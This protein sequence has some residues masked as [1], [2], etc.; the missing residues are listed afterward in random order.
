VRILSGALRTFLFAALTVGASAQAALASGLAFDSV[1]KFQ[2]A[3]G[4]PEPPG[5]FAPD[6]AAAAS[7]PSSGSTS[8]GP[9]GLGAAMAKAQAAMAMFRTG[10]AERHYVAGAKIRIDNV[11]THT[12]QITDC[13]ARTLTTLDLLK[14]EYTVVS[15]DQPSTSAGPSH[16]GAPRRSSSDNLKMKMQLTSRSLGPLRI[17]GIATSGYQSNL[18]TTV[19]NSAGQTQSFD[20]STTGYYTAID[21]P[22]TYCGGFANATPGPGSMAMGEYQ[23]AMHALSLSK[24]NSR[25]TVSQSGPAIPV[26]KLAL[27]ELAATGSRTGGFDIL[28]ERG[29]VRPI[30]NNDPIFGIPPGFTKVSSLP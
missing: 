12:A 28:I 20:M 19:T 25:F 27:Y 1:T 16:P 5:N 7:A 22:A 4:S 24:S 8:S 14:R 17:D 10:T 2:E 29:N 23:M 13:S 21:E 3:N 9:F 15:L 11:A 30:S 26:G 18:N 6:F